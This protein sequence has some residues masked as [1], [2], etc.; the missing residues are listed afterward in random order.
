MNPYQYVRADPI[1]QVDPTGRGAVLNRNYNEGSKFVEQNPTDPPT[2]GVDDREIRQTLSPRIWRRGARLNWQ[3]TGQRQSVSKQW[4]RTQ[5]ELARA[6]LPGLDQR[7]RDLNQRLRD[8]DDRIRN[9]E[10]AAQLHGGR[11][12]DQLG[13]GASVFF[14]LI[15]LREERAPLSEETAALRFLTAG[16]RRLMER[17][18]N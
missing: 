11:L 6:R 9:V 8:L 16:L 17:E 7:L 5:Q 3:P 1:S 14:Q 15:G 13:G 2:S 4:L 10:S 12:L 18:N